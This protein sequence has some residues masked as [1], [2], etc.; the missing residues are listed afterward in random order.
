LDE[1]KALL[2]SGVDANINIS[3]SDSILMSACRNGNL[4]IKKRA[5]KNE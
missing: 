1:I 3:S 4:V 5:N 2:D